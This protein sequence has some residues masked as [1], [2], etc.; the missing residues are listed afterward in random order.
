MADALVTWLQA[1][2]LSRAIVSVTWLWP[3]AETLHF[4]GLALV[5]GI[6]GFLDVRLIGGFR[7]VPV[8]AAHG[9]MPYAIGGF[10]LNLF[11]G[12]IFFVGHPEQ[13]VHNVA[14]WFKVGCLAVAGAN[15]LVFERIVST[16]VLPLGPGEDTPPLAKAIGAISLAAWAG[17]L[18]WGRMLPFI[19]DAY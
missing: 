14:W 12:A 8:R 18:Y 3:V 13:Y 6:A 19:G 16:Q 5:L 9:L 17:V 2:S 11:T 1:T 4:V 15:A 7:Q 10:L